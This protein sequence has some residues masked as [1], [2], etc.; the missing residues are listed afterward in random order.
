MNKKTANLLIICIC[1][2]VLPFTLPAKVFAEDSKTEIWSCSLDE[3]IEHRSIKVGDSNP[4][5]GIMMTPTNLAK[6]QVS[7]TIN[8]TSV[9][10]V[11]GDNDTATVT[12]LKEGSTTLNLSVTTA[13]GDVLSDTSVISVY[14]PINNIS[15][16][17]S[18]K[19]TFYRGADNASWVRSENVPAGQK[20][21]V[22]GSCGNYYYLELPDTYTF[23]DN[24][25]SRYT[26]AL[27]SQIYIPVTQI[28]LNTSN[29]DIA[30]GKSATIGKTITPNIATD[31]TVSWTSN[32]TNSATVDTKGVITG[33]K[34][35]YVI[36]TA[37]TN[38][39]GKTAACKVSVYK[40]R[41]KVTAKIK[42]N[43]ALL[44]GADANEKKRSGIVSA[45]QKL[46][47]T[48]SCGNYYF[49]E[50]PKEY[51]FGDGNSSRMAY[52]LKSKVYIP[53]E[54][55]KLDKKDIVMND[56]AT[57]KL[58][59]TV[60]PD[61][62]TNKKVIWSV[63]KNNIVSV[64]S[65]GTVKGI[66]SGKAV[67]NARTESDGKVATC[68][69]SVIKNLNPAK[70][71]NFKLSLIK[72][73]FEH[74]DMKYT[75]CDGAT[76]YILYEG[77]K[78]I[79]GTIKW[80]DLYESYGSYEN[81][82]T[83]W[84][85]STVGKTYYYKVVASKVY[86]RD[87]FDFVTLATKTSNIL[88]VVCGKPVL[89]AKPDGKTKVKLSWVKMTSDS[90]KKVSYEIYRKTKKQKTYKKIKTVSKKAATSFKDQKLKRDTSY[91]YKIKA[92]YINKKKKKVYSPYSDVVTVKT[93]KK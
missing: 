56:T 17:V 29:I 84:G 3:R 72:T 57:Q 27:K 51:S 45:G 89:S 13:G 59:A 11:S 50:L 93:K 36:I 74:N 33:K 81:G 85:F 67:I 41:S 92:F 68:N 88:K 62:A 18:A 83:V 16:Q 10:G 52:V 39:A 64:D 48:G 30:E 5:F 87:A 7:W 66:N 61:I 35:G 34:E 37:T 79:D 73:N 53:V 25:A 58:V 1:M 21:T 19:A 22:I 40:P 38:S 60:L 9:A 63:N 26:Y 4:N 47:I 49:V 65:K 20:V 23:D 31:Q 46:S 77:E 24:R 44:F 86:A 70:L 28:S 71:E 43:T 14:T 54:S 55:I 6:E 8:D 75:R 2:F 78:R 91:M 15:G 90:Y 76:E 69:V 32:K 12:G 42:E 80:E 82:D